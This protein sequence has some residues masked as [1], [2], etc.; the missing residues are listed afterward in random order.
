MKLYLENSRLLS[1]EID[2]HVVAIFRSE[3]LGW[4]DWFSRNGLT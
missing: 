1:G 4:L 2:P 3:Y